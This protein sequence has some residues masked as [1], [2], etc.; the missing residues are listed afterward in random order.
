MVVVVV[1]EISKVNKLTGKN[2]T[3]GRLMFNRCKQ[4]INTYLDGYS[5]EDVMT[6]PAL[7]LER[8]YLSVNRFHYTLS[9][10]VR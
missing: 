8:T 6:V 3:I 2:I 7:L 4:E 10:L 5:T 1:V 9:S